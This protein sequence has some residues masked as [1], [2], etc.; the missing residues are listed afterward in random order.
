MG[1]VLGVMTNRLTNR[2]LF[3]AFETV[4]REE[5]FDD[6]LIFTPAGVDVKRKRVSG[7][8][9]RN[10]ELVKKAAGYPSISYDIGYY[11]SPQTIAQV[12]KIKSTPS[13]PFINYGLGNKWAIHKR[14]AIFSRL[15]PHLIPT[16]PIRNA[17][18]VIQLLE[19]NG[20]LM[21]KPIN[22]KE[23]KGIIRL[24]KV[25]NTYLLEKE[26]QK[27][28]VP[29]A[30]DLSKRIRTLLHKEQYIGQKWI[31]IYN[32]DGKA[33]DIRSLM[34]KDKQGEWRLVGMA[35]RQGASGKVT[36]NLMDGGTAY[37]VIPYLQAQFGRKHSRHLYQRLEELS[38]YIPPC[39]EAAYRRPQADLG[40]D[41]AVDKTGHI[42][43]IEVNIKPG[44]LPFRD[45]FAIGNREDAIRLPVQY[46]GYCLR[47]GK[48]GKTPK[49]LLAAV[50][51]VKLEDEAVPTPAISSDSLVE[52]EKP[53]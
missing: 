4:A 16:E 48:Q 49:A 29:S 2:A 7:Y 42:Y 52:E 12:R 36:S 19:K 20:T 47:S 35:V 34:Q 24:S 26:L 40:I 44:K 1:N 39:L 43:I 23:G 8:T 31:D 21:L 5:G 46:A 10:G 53:K 27:V 13:L 41:L 15:R 50:N 37:P 33:Y 51:S 28:V 14:L 38:L 3:Q 6:V 22:G 11:S 45:V 25:G 17:R 18:Q 9:V 32:Q 30:T